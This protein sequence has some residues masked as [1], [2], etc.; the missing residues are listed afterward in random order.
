[1]HHNEQRHPHQKRKNS[2]PLSRRILNE[3]STTLAAALQQDVL[4]KNKNRKAHHIEWPEKSTPAHE[5]IHDGR[6]LFAI[7][8]REPSDTGWM[9]CTVSA[10]E[11]LSTI[12]W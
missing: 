12:E 6:M 4:C 3:L 10:A 5:S 8:V 2:A 9:L 1:M 7:R 11:P